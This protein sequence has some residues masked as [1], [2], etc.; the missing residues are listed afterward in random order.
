M[1]RSFDWLFLRRHG[2]RDVREGSCARDGSGRWLVTYRVAP[3]PP[4]RRRR[5]ELAHL[6][7]WE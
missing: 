4:G 6:V 3:P 7:V 2:R 1:S 5:L